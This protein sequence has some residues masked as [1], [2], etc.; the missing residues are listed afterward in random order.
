LGRWFKNK[1][2]YKISKTRLATETKAE[3]K[4]IS[5]LYLSPFGESTRRGIGAINEHFVEGV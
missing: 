2:A 5:F 4:K 1:W 3:F